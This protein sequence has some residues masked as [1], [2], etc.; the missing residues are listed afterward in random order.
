MDNQPQEHLCLPLSQKA[1]GPASLR[2]MRG[3]FTGAGCKNHSGAHSF[4]QM[5]LQGAAGGCM[6]RFWDDALEVVLKGVSE[7]FALL[8]TAQNDK[9]SLRRTD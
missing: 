1:D 5:K 7:R 9:N 2:V 3:L 6:L 8:R 4:C